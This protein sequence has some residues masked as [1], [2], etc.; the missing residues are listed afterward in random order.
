MFMM[1]FQLLLMVRDDLKATVTFMR[2]QRS[3][4]DD[5]DKKAW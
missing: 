2:E 5:K 4:F 3:S 1:E